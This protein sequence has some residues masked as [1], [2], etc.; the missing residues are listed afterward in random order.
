MHMYEVGCVY[1]CHENRFT[2]WSAVEGV[3]EGG[4]GGGGE[5]GGGGGGWCGVL[6]EC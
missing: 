5:K 3:G 6:A 4:G 2:V 1:V